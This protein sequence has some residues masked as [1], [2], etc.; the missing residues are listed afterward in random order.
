MSKKLYPD[1]DINDLVNDD[2]QPEETFYKGGV[3]SGKKGHTTQK[4]QP[5]NGKYGFMT[6]GNYNPKADAENRKESNAKFDQAV[7]EDKKRREAKSK[8]NR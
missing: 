4:P 3:G 8:D 2:L 7:A 1:L 5:H 6:H